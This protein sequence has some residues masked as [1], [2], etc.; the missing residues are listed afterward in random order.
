MAYN[1]EM[2]EAIRTLIAPI[3]TYPEMPQGN[4]EADNEQTKTYNRPNEMETFTWKR[5]LV[6]MNTL[7]NYYKKYQKTAYFLILGQCSPAL[8]AQ[9]E[10]KKDLKK[11]IPSPAV[12]QGSMQ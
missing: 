1:N 7:Q 8:W 12:D 9:L 10:E 4:V 11:S 5:Q 6:G 3:F 2:G